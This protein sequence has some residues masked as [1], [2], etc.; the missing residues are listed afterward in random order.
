MFQAGDYIDYILK[1][2]SYL[3][4]LVRNSNSLN[5]TDVNIN[6]EDFFKGLL[7]LLGYE[8]DN[9]NFDKQ[10]AAYIDLI[11]TTNKTAVQVTSSNTNTKIK[12]SIE[13]FY[14]DSTKKDYKLK[15]LL[16]SRE[17]KDYKTDFT[18]G[19][20]YDF[21]AK[22]DVLDVPKLLAIIRAKPLEELSKIADFFKIQTSES[23]QISECN[24]VETILSLISYLSNPKNRVPI[25]KTS[26]VDPEYKIYNRFA[27]HA[28]FLIDQYTQLYGHYFHSLEASRKGIDTIQAEIISSYLKAESDSALTTENN[29]PKKALNTLTNYFENKLATNNRNFD[30]QAIRFYLL[31][32]MIK[33][34][35]FPNIV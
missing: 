16:I 30:K 4:S 12:K 14:K 20:K 25:P 6:C 5:L 34:N 3:Q 29:D 15:V 26:N 24:E 8:F 27:S 11:D 13:G 19:G 10:N 28:N 17:A 1:K 35:V 22:D 2:L 33:C 18:T 7:N 32:E 23:K 9:T 31:D 21:K